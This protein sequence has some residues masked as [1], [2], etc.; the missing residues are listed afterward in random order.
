MHVIV[1]FQSL[2]AYVKQPVTGNCACKGIST[3]G[4]KQES[5]KKNDVTK[6]IPSYMKLHKSTVATFTL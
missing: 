6:V 1:S 2:E 4:E 5:R 3:L